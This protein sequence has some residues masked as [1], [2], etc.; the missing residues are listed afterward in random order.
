MLL[1]QPKVYFLKDMFLF[2]VFEVMGLIERFRLE[3]RILTPFH[4]TD[5][6]NNKEIKYLN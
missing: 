4:Y 6:N 3:A 2:S 1:K 5:T